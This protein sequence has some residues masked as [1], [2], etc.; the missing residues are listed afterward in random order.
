MT[1]SRTTKLA[2]ITA[3]VWIVVEVA[4]WSAHIGDLRDIDDSGPDASQA[5]SL[6]IHW[7]GLM[8]AEFLHLY[9]TS[10][11]VLA[12]F[13]TLIQMFVLFWIVIALWRYV[14]ERKAG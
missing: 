13:V 8:L 7:P 2:T 1:Y 3:I 11:L 14:C 10:G 6:L 12:E 9:S 4:L 5:A